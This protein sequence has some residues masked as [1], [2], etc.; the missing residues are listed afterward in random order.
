MNL[1][2]ANLVAVQF[3]IFVGTMSWLVYSRLPSTKP[4]EPVEM[5]GS[6]VGPVATVPPSFEPQN[7]RPYPTDYRVDREPPQLVVEKAPPTAPTARPVVTRPSTSSGFENASVVADSP[8]YMDEDQEPAEAVVPQIVAY[9]AQ[10]IVFSNPRR[11][12]NHCQPTP[13]HGMRMTFRASI[14]H[15]GEPRQR[16]FA[17]VPRWNS[18][19]PS[20]RPARAPGTRWHR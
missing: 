17:V 2:V 11:F 3:G 5:H 9:P 6:I 8:T 18:D 7:Q 19:A 4:P 15:R 10:I 20:C 1:G 14:R 13:H 16:V 12:A